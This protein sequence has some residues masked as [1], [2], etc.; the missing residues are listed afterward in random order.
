LRVRNPI[1][2]KLSPIPTP[3]GPSNRAS[4]A[5]TVSTC[6]TK[7]NYGRFI[8]DAIDNWLTQTYPHIGVV[9]DDGS[10]D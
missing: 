9:V 7:Y 1:F 8:A 5:P 2:A 10:T 3:H 4:T 6:V